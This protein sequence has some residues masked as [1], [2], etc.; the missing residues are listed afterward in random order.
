MAAKAKK[1]ESRSGINRAQETIQRN[2]HK[3]PGPKRRAGANAIQIRCPFHPDKGPSC[4][5]QL[6][7]TDRYPLGFFY[8][9]GCKEGRGEWNKLAD[10]LG[11]ERISQQDLVQTKSY[12]HDMEETRQQLLGVKEGS[13]GLDANM[14]ALRVEVSMPFPPEDTW[15]KIPGTMLAKVGALLAFDEGTEEKVVILPVKMNRVVIGCIKARWSKDKSKKNPSYK[16]SKGEGWA[17]RELLF[18]YDYAVRLARRKKRALVIVEGPRD[19]LRLL[20][21]GIPAVAITGTENWSDYKGNLVVATEIEKIIICMDSDPPGIEAT[22]AIRRY[23]RHQVDLRIFR[24]ADIAERMRVEKGLDETPK[25]DPGNMP[26]KYVRKLKR[27][28]QL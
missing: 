14:A 22:N 2:L 27:L 18:P 21:Y 17:K 19:A 24:T 20:Q 8:C 23:L 5:L 7:A 25:V 4:M 15:R 11:L 6:A 3:I 16:N 10:K 26:M 28:C 9:F 13:N 1:E 12:D